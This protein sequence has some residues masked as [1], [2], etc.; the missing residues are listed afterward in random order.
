MAAASVGDRRT[1]PP[2]ICLTSDDTAS[3]VQCVHR[4]GVGTEK[5][6]YLFPLFAVGMVF[7]CS[8]DYGKTES[9]EDIVPEFRFSDAYFSRY[10]D[11]AVT[12]EIEAQKIEQYKSDG[13]SY[14]RKARFRTFDGEGELDTEGSCNL[15]AAD[16]Q[17]EI[18]WMFDDISVTLHTQD[19]KIFADALRYDGKSEQMTSGRDDEVSI[20]KKDTVI[21]GRGFS[22]SG[23][24]KTFSF[25]TQVAGNI[26]TDE[27]EESAGGES[28]AQE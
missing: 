19:M 3:A 26:I 6:K 21:T 23:V 1:V 13:A 22:S 11:S 24:S 9:V 4:G 18:Y 12:M 25:L 8:L 14:A 16:T 15:L 28:G 17:D 10:E 7:G 27:D 2:G 5:M 20:E